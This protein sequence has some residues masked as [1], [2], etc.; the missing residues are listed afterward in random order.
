MK[1]YLATLDRAGAQ[2]NAL[3]VVIAIGLVVLDMTVLLSQH[4]IARL[5]QVERLTDANNAAPAA[6]AKPAATMT[7][8]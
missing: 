7:G 3:L 8:Q 2:V 6:I 1:Q 4:V 5:P